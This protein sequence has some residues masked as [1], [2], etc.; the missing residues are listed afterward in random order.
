MSP[1]FNAS[2]LA[3]F[4]IADFT[5]QRIRVFDEN[6]TPLV[7]P[8]A[9]FARV[10]NPEGLAYVPG[11]PGMVV[12]SETANPGYPNVVAFDAFGNPEPLPPNAFAGL[13]R[14]LFL[15]YA[16]IGGS[17][18]YFV[19]DYFTN[20]L[21]VF[22]A[23]GSNVRLGSGSFAQMINP[24]AALYDPH[25]SEVY[26]TNGGATRS[27]PIRRAARSRE[28]RRSAVIRWAPSSTQTTTRST[29]P[30]AGRSAPRSTARA[31]QLAGVTQFSETPAAVSRPGAF[32]N[33]SASALFTGIAF[34]PFTKRIYVADAGDSKIDAFTEAGVP[35]ALPAGA[36]GTISSM[37]NPKAD[38][39]AIL[40]VP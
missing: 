33:A 34:D 22:D 29:W 21:A 19:P 11:V 27:R 28:A 32:A 8:S 17:G 13:S 36:F 38:P 39:M 2:A 31:P 20:S 5:V 25:D 4:Y 23:R 24:V 26:V 12:V 16:T 30:T 14:P 6:G 1:P 18:R 40:F 9:A 15:A 7:L 35:V 37:T 10:S 3:A